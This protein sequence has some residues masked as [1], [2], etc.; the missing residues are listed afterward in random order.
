MSHRRDVSPIHHPSPDA[1]RGAES[2]EANR[3]NERRLSYMVCD[4]EDKEAPRVHNKGQPTP[5]IDDNSLFNCSSPQYL[6]L[7][8]IRQMMSSL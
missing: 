7:S 8:R 4:H 3:E 6:L 1:G 5:E 2:A